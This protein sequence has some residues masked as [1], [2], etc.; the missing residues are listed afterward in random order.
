MLWI[1]LPR[2]L[3]FVLAA[4]AV[5]GVGVLVFGLLSIAGQL[6]GSVAIDLLAPSGNTGFGWSE[7]L[8]LALVA[9]AVVIAT[10][11]SRLSPAARRPRR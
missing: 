9:L 2:W 4:W 6:L 5:R 8:A 7:W 3:R 11:P 10:N 1:R